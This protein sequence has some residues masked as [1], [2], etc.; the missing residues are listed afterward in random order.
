M[1]LKRKRSTPTFSSPSS[2][3]SSNSL[4]FFYA[5]TKPTPSEALYQKPTWSFPT[6]SSSN[7]SSPETRHSHSSDLGTRLDSRTRKRHRDDRPD[8]HSIYGAS[9]CWLGAVI[10]MST[11]ADVCRCAA[12]TISRLYEAQRQH[13]RAEPVISSEPS[14]Q[15]AAPAQRSTLHSFWNISSAPQPPTTVPMMVDAMPTSTQRGE[16]RCE[17][18]DGSIR[19][20]D[21]MELDGGQLELE[22]ACSSCTRQVCNRCA[23]L[24]NERICLACV[25]TRR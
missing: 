13:P 19:Q 25:T 15:T 11:L 18:C 14:H 22:A 2:I 5:Q 1:A 24:G 16:M 4:P 6:Y 21:A 8:E 9:S 23:V 10:E 3:D 20:D 7:S 12:S 17:D